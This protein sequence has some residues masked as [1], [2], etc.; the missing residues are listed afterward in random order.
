MVAFFLDL[1]ERYGLEAP[2]FAAYCQTQRGGWFVVVKKA[3]SSFFATYC[4]LYIR[5]REDFHSGFTLTGFYLS[6]FGLGFFPLN[7]PQGGF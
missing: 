1:E 6:F 4:R 7:S 3:F 2:V 5:G